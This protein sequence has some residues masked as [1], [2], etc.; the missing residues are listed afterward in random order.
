[1]S[2]SK[3]NAQYMVGIPR[4]SEM[5]RFYQKEAYEQGVRVPTYL[6]LL[7]KDRYEA[8]TGEGQGKWF[9]RGWQGTATP[10]HLVSESLGEE[11]SPD[12]AIAMFGGIDP[13]DEPT[14]RLPI[15]K[16]A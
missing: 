2:R 13:D 3:A 16:G 1:M 14:E 5:Q 15:V 11:I 7:L 6:Y 8:L 12:E 9:P 10:L 4:D